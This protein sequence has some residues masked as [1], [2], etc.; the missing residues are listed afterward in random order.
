MKNNYFYNIKKLYTSNKTSILS[1]KYNIL[2]FKV[3]K[4]INKLEIYNSF[5]KIF[6]IKIKKIRTLLVKRKIKCKSNKSL[7][8]KI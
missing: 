2:V 6:G 8:V 5:S 1:K 4:N 3:D 7:I